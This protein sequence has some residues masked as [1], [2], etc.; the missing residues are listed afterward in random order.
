MARLAATAVLLLCLLAVASCRVIEV[1]PDTVFAISDEQ[2]H[3]DPAVPRETDA[4]ETIS[5]LPTVTVAP[6]AILRLPSNRRPYLHG[7]LR[8]TRNHDLTHYRSA[9]ACPGEARVL[10][11]VLP[12]EAREAEVEV[13]AVAEP[14]PDSR[15]DTDGE[16]KPF[17]GDKEENE[18]VKA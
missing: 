16:Q 3:A 9:F 15:P 7:F 5:S 18:P 6:E 8:L 12:K 10:P 14:D 1:E 4:A 2:S 13:D 17:H 11:A